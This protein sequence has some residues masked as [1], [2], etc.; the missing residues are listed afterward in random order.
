MYALSTLMFLVVMILLLL[1]NMKPDEKAAG[2]KNAKIYQS[3]QSASKA[4]Q[5][6]QS[7]DVESGSGLYGS[8]SFWQVEFSM[9]SA[10]KVPVTNRSLCI[11]GENISIRKL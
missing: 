10:Q 11:T 6:P 3:C 8:F 7:Y 1:I 9:V 2:A 5:I 4:S